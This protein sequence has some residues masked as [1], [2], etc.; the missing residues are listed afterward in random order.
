MITEFRK[1]QTYL[2]NND[3]SE[4]TFDFKITDPKELVVVQ[5]DIS[6]DP[7]VIDWIERGGVGLN[8][9][10]VEF[11]SILGGGKVIFTD[12]LPAGKRIYIKLAN[13]EPTQ[14]SLFR[15]Q[16]DFKLR[17]IEN[18]LDFIV[19]QATRLSDKTERS[20]KFADH[21]SH[22]EST[23]NLQMPEFPMPH[24]MPIMDEEA[25]QLHMKPILTI[26]EDAGV[27]QMI[28]DAQ[29]DADT[30]NGRL[31]LLEP[32][33]TQAEADINA[34]EGQIDNIEA[35]A[36][37][38]AADAAAAL[39]SANNAEASAAAAEA[40]AQAAADSAA[41]AIGASVSNRIQVTPYAPSF[42]GAIVE[43]EYGQEV[44]KFGLEN[45]ILMFVKMSQ[46]FIAGRPIKLGFS[47]Y[48]PTADNTSKHR[49][50][51][52]FTLIREGLPV[53]DTTY[54][55]SIIAETNLINIV[56][57]FN[58]FNL[59]LTSDGTIVGEDVQPGDAISIEIKRVDASS[60][61]DPE[62]VRLHKQ[63]FELSFA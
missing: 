12:N 22:V 54:Q 3:L 48:S 7:T 20:L 35:D 4:Y 17:S 50:Q 57:N 34:L 13:D 25:L 44:F 37:Q 11:D 36:A 10:E 41:A 23:V 47:G 60:D 52:T 1:W 55:D 49:F 33:V 26:L 24:G 62:L 28:R 16:K 9:Q 42:M 5:L 53:T 21:Y 39:V 32:R 31:D 61:E 14:P 56:D 30:A 38:A 46:Y 63:T 18:A 15:E 27:M 29:E 8:I 45:K 43:E 58:S 6:S 51:I 19:N 40:D 59:Q 2:G